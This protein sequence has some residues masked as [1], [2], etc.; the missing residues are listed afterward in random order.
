MADANPDDAGFPQTPE[1]DHLA[2]WS[3]AIEMHTGSNYSIPVAHST[4]YSSDEESDAR[5]ISDFDSGSDSEFDGCKTYDEMQEMKASKEDEEDHLRE[6]E[7]MLDAEEYAE[8]W[9]EHR[10][11]WV[12]YIKMV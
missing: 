6:L 10:F 5:N 2:S 8:L 3:G 12:H 7:D 9:N 4:D 1:A 11:F